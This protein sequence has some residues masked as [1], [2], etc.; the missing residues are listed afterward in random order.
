MGSNM[1]SSFSVHKRLLWVGIFGVAMAFLESAVVIYLR[2][3]YYPAG[4]NFPLA[5]IEGKIAVTEILRELATIIMLLSVGILTG[6]DLAE[7]F[8]YFIYCFAIWDIFYYVFLYLVIG[9][10]ESLMTWDILFLIPVTWVGPVITPVLVS[11]TMILLAVF[12][13]Y[14]KQRITG[15]RLSKL[16]ET[17]LL[18]GAL[19]IFLSFIWDY[20]T[21]LF[22]YFEL[23]EIWHFSG[24]DKLLEVANNYIPRKFNWILFCLGELVIAGSIY[25]VAADKRSFN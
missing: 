11:L 23:K 19:I 2:V 10:P 1:G 16:T 13:L 18:A 8:S 17:L 4:F 25:S 14:K 24:N 3:I 22:E 21:Y 9:W 15:F 12:I 6:R 7:R 20:S 5:P